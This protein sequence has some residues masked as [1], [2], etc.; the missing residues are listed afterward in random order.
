M[1]DIIFEESDVCQV[2]LLNQISE[3]FFRNWQCMLYPLKNILH[4]IIDKDISQKKI[5]L[6]SSL[7]SYWQ[8]LFGGEEWYILDLNCK[9]FQFEMER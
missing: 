6:S 1:N 4:C 3:V 2:S 5:P 7:P 8:I 9:L